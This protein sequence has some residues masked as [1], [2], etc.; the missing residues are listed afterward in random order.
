MGAHRDR[1]VSLIEDFGA[2]RKPAPPSSLTPS[3]LS[4]YHNDK[5]K[6]NTN[7]RPSGLLRTAWTNSGELP[8]RDMTA[9]EI[10]RELGF[11]DLYDILAPIIYHCVPSAVLAMLQTHFHDLIRFDLRGA[12]QEL[13]TLR[14]P[15]LVVLT[16]L[17][18]P[19]MWFPLKSRR[20]NGVRVSL[21][22]FL[23]VRSTLPC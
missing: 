8:H 3:P 9:A 22:C 6:T 20:L 17:R 21:L 19:M 2:L 16:E 23:I 10:A 5:S 11:T 1:I 15:D 4:P 13:A 14:L 7:S 12:T 18:M